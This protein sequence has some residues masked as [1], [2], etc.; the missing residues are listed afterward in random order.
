MS[1]TCA[2]ESIQKNK[3]FTIQISIKETILNVSFLLK[4]ITQ[5]LIQ[6]EILIAVN[7][8][9]T[10]NPFSGCLSTSTKIRIIH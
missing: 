3:K 4:G 8:N 1:W 7:Q 9:E 10:L 5:M 6:V 2:I